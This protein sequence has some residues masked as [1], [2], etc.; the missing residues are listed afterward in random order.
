MDGVLTIFKE[1]GMTSHD[2]VSKVRKIYH[3]HKVGHGGTLDPQ[4][5]G[6][7]PILIGKATKLN[8][9][10]SG[11]KTY[12]GELTLG[13]RT[14]TDD[15]T[16]QSLEIAEV[17]NLTESKIR[18]IFDSFQGKQLQKP[19]MY[20][21][22]KIRGKKLY[23]YARAGEQ[24][25]V[26]TA[27]INISY[28]RVLTIDLPEKKILFEVECSRGTYIRSLCRD[29][30]EKLG[31]VGHMSYLIRLKSGT[32]LTIHRAVPL[33][34]LERMTNTE[35]HDILISLEDMLSEYPEIRL[36]ANVYFNLFNGQCLPFEHSSYQENTL[37][38][39]YA[40]SFLGLGKIFWKNE[41]RVLKIELLL[42]DR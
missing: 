28:I 3:T 4:V 25:E 36:D 10:L 23:E 20:S 5:A 12:I 7:L 24:V 31:T 1:K 35:L 42:G 38:R 15:F 16:G 21:A 8:N 19:P 37:Y 13:I 2:V 27:E 32:G 33:K 17:P 18:E 11:T 14:D 40:D 41:R 6:V 30:A 39:I 34:F 26:L 29:I 22:R 9:Y